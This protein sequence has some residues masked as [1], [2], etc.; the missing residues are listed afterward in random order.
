MSIKKVV[1]VGDSVFDNGDYVGPN[2]DVVNQLNQRL[3]AEYNAELIAVDGATTKDVW[4]QI[5]NLCEG[6]GAILLSIGG[7]D[8]LMNA[9]VLQVQVNKVW[10]SQRRLA[11][12]VDQFEARYREAVAL[13]VNARPML[14]ICTIYEPWFSNPDLRRIAKF[15]LIPY[16]QAIFRVAQEHSLFVLDLREIFTEKEDFTNAIEPSECGG[17]KL[18]AAIKT[19]MLGST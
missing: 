7:N 16:N 5:D 13:C 11:D 9:Q 14:G 6:Q 3:S 4:K 19:L 15:T 1:L 2:Q 8:V 18:A 12:L 17:A 10:E